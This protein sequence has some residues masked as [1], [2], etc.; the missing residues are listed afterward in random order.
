MKLKNILSTILLAGVATAMVAADSAN[1]QIRTG[2]GGPGHTDWDFTEPDRRGPGGGHRNGQNEIVLR[3]GGEIFGNRGGRENGTLY[4]KRE[5]QRQHPNIRLQNFDLDSVTVIGVSEARRSS[6]STLTLYLNRQYQDQAVLEHRGRGH[7]GM[8]S[9]TMVPR[10]RSQ[11][12]PG[13]QTWQIDFSAAT[14]VQRVIVQLD[15]EGRHGGGGHGGGRVRMQK[16]G[17][18]KATKI[19]AL[20]QVVPVNQWVDT[21][22]IEGTK[23]IVTIQSVEA[24]Y[25]GGERRMLDLRGTITDGQKLRTSFRREMKLNYLIVTAMSNDLIGSQGKYEV[26]VGASGRR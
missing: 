2:R 17:E 21:I 15:R 16:V 5:I 4:L 25:Q 12:G 11:R 26:Q 8:D 9:A 24:V 3:M 13:E 19:V 14:R 6:N 20:P 18:Y 7:R 23:K 22:H 1:A 10:R